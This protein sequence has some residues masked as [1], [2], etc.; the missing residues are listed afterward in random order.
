M[1][2]VNWW[3]KKEAPLFTGLHF[4][5]GGG[6]AAADAGDGPSPIS[7]TGGSKSTVGDYTVHKFT[8]SGTFNVASGSDPTGGASLV[9]GGGGAGGFDSGGGG[10]GGAVVYSVSLPLVPGSMSVTVGNG[11]ASV[12]SYFPPPD[13]VPSWGA[14]HGG[15]DS[16][17]AHPGGTI[18]GYGGNAGGSPAPSPNYG[19]SPMS[20]GNSAQ[21]GSL[22]GAGRSQPD[23]AATTSSPALNSPY[24][25]PGTGTHNVMRNK[26]GDARSNHPGPQSNPGWIGGGGGGAGAEGSNGDKTGGGNGGQGWDAESNIPWISSSEGNAGNF[27]GGG[28]S[29]APDP[30]SEPAGEGG[31]GGGGDGQSG[32]GSV[33]SGE[34]NTG[35]GGGGDD[36]GQASGAGGPGCVYIAYTTTAGGG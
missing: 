21:L 19:P 24:P 8:S 30:G 23:P 34:T 12:T 15:E 16:S 4:G 7:A 36:N 22:G 35:G 33:Q 31:P 32:G 2:I 11:G 17:F 3:F 26:G 10:G 27:A 28:G 5:F 18:T 9:I 6:G 13:P 1:S 29:G 20:A 25:T 14:T